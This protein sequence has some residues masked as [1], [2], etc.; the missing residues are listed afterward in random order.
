[1]ELIS[2]YATMSVWREGVGAQVTAPQN[3]K[4]CDP[5]GTRP[6][7]SSPQYPT[8]TVPCNPHNHTVQ[9]GLGLVL[10]M[11][12][13]GWRPRHTAEKEP[14]WAKISETPGPLSWIKTRLPL[15]F[16]ENGCWDFLSLH[17]KGL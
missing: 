4:T 2:N 16:L 15:Q 6:G 9:G 13:L 12:T 10:Q 3:R 8:N 17:K 14:A 11:K 5:L 1:M 7:V